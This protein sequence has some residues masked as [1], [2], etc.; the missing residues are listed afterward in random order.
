MRGFV[1]RIPAVRQAAHVVAAE[2]DV[3][4]PVEHGRQLATA[5]PGAV[6][7]VVAGTGHLLPR[8]SPAQVTHALLALMERAA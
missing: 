7:T 3:L 1:T 2:M 4:T 6:L 8:E 5:L